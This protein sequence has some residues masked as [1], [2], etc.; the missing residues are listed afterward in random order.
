[1][2]PGFEGVITAKAGEP[3]ILDTQ[4]GKHIVLV[5]AKSKPLAKKQVAIFEK[6]ALASKE[7]FNEYYAKANKFAT[8]ANGSFEGYKAA[9]D[10]LGTYSHKMNVL[11]STSSYGSVESAKEVTRWV[12]DNK[13]GKASNIITVNNNFFFVVGIKAAHKEGYATVEET[14]SQIKSIL[15]NEKLAEKKKAEVAET[16]AGKTSLQEI[17]DAC[18]SS[19]N[20]QSDVA[21]ASMMNQSLDPALIGAIAAAPENK[22]CGPVAGKFA[23]YVFQVTGRETGSFY[24]EDDANN[25]A[26]QK[27]QYTSQMILPTMMNDA[28]VVDNRARFY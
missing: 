8:I 11:E 9:V 27:A 7:T 10:S 17:A 15:Y 20:S 16:M 23:V 13:A 1:M 18:N 28:D 21:F 22:I 12:F 14:A 24:T 25:M 3:F 4:Y 6:T 2:I 26:A 19:V 5:S